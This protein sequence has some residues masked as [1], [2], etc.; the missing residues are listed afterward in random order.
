MMSLFAIIIKKERS[1]KMQYK[2]IDM[3]LYPRKNH[4]EYF[5]E[6]AYPYTGMTANVNVTKIKE[7]T[8]EKGYSFFLTMNH[9]IARAANRIPEFKMR[10]KNDGIIEYKHCGTSHVIL[11]PDNTFCYCTLHHE[12]NYEDYIAYAISEQDKYIEKA[13]IEDNEETDSLL[14]VSALPWVHYTSLIQAVPCGNESNPRISFGKYEEVQGKLLMPL[15]VLVHHALVDG[16]HLGLFYKYV[17]EEIS[18][19]VNSDR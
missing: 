12:K 5:K 16:F 15:T 4:F 18:L 10:I 13:S 3:N 9:I 2:K 19:L 11:L 17:E 7:Y 6:M 14:F 1:G 8:K